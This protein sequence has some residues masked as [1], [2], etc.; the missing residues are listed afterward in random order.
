[1]LKEKVKQEIDKLNEDQLRRV[2]IFIAS[3]QLEAEK[4]SV[5]L[6]KRTTPAER[7][8]D[9]EEWASQFPKTGGGLPDK[10]CDRENIYRED[11]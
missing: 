7:A 1:M 5:P 9:L 10:A 6:W 3:I 2:E 11:T 4:S 8:R